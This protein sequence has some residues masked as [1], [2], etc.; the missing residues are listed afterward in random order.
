MTHPNEVLIR[1]WY[2]ARS[3]GDLPEVRELLSEDL[4]WHDPYPEPRGGDLLGADAVINQVFGAAQETGAIFRLHDVMASDEHA[5]ALVEW[6][7][8]VSGETMDGREVA[9]FHVRDGKIAES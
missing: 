6:S 8:T 5:V 4:R 2:D 1:C 9:V 3:R 7:A